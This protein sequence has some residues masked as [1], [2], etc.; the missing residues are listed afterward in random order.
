MKK[1]WRKVIYRGISLPYEVREDGK[2]RRIAGADCIG[3]IRKSRVIKPHLTSGNGRYLQVVLQIEKKRY[4]PTVHGLVATAFLSS[5][6]DK[7]GHTDDGGKVNVNHRDCDPSNNHYSNLEWTTPRQNSEHAAANNKFWK[8]EQ[9]N[10]AVLTADQVR[11]IRKRKLGGEGRN[12]LAREYGVSHY[13]IYAICKR[14]T[15]KHVE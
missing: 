6:P 15:W 10:T 2:V 13:A 1:Q 12:A 8:G 7:Y 4:S 14:K 5:P 3:R 11:E 9:I